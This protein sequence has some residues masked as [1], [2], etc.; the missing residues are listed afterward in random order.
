MRFVPY[1]LADMIAT[2]RLYEQWVSV[3]VQTGK[4]ADA[5]RVAQNACDAHPSSA[6]L[7]FLKI[8]LALVH[9]GNQCTCFLCSDSDYL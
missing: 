7:W 3:L 1:E 8:R 5:L 4:P 6:E 9:N 2:P